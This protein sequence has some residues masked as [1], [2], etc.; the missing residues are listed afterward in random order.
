[1]LESVGVITAV[2]VTVPRVVG[3]HEHVAVIFGEVPPVN[4]LM[5]PAIL[6]PFARKVTRED[7]ETVMAIFVVV[8]YVAVEVPE[9]SPN[10]LILEVSF[11]SVTVTVIVSYPALDAS[12]TAL[13]TTI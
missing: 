7:I 1:M 11:T 5:Q 4:F 3:L 13:R 8:L 2:R 10:E 9:D 6:F 12:S